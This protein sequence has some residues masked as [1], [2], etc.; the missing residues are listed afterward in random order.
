MSPFFLCYSSGDVPVDHDANKG[1]KAMAETI[2]ELSIEYVEDEKII[3]KQIE[4][5]VLTRG[6]WTTIM[7]LYQEMDKKTEEYGATKVSIRR[8]QKRNGVFRQQS[9]FN[10]S[11]AK[12][13]HAICAILKTWYP[14]T[15]EA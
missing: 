12:Q 4:K 6:N 5:E 13:A 15:A 9:K 11:S 10:I 2:D 7:Y 14:E 8:Y 1:G 3:V